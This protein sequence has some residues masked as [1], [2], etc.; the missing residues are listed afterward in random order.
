MSTAGQTADVAAA[1]DALLELSSTQPELATIMARLVVADEAHRTPRFSNALT[2]AL[3]NGVPSDSRPKRTGRRAA[4]AINPFAIY[5]EGGED[6]LRQQLSALTLEQ[7]R[8]IIAEHG[9]DNDRLAMKWKSQDR[10]VE[11]IV[12]KVSSRVAKGSAFR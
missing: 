8:D 6:L 11:R 10:V 5:A 1:G 3:L 2:Q 7:L 12:E 9:M 4:G